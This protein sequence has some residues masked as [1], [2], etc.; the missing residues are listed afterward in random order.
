MNEDQGTPGN[1]APDMPPTNQMPGMVPE[2]PQQPAVTPQSSESPG[3]SKK[4]LIIGLVVLLLV[5]ILAGLWFFVFNKQDDKDTPAT[6]QSVSAPDADVTHFVQVGTEVKY[7]DDGELK[8]LAS[9]GDKDVVVEAV[10]TDSGTELRY[11]SYK[12]VENGARNLDAYG[13][14]TA[15]GKQESF[16]FVAGKDY[17]YSNPVVSPDGSKII[18]EESDA[19]GFM[20]ELV[21]Y[22]VSDGSTKQAYKP[23]DT[24]SGLYTMVAWKDDNTAL[25]QVQT[26]R[27]CDGPRTAELVALDINSG[28][29][30]PFY[31][32]D[33]KKVGY[34]DFLESADGNSL[35]LYG[36][37]FNRLFSGFDGAEPG[38][39]YGND[40]IFSINKS[41]GEA[42]Q[43]AEI[44]ADNNFFGRIIGIADDGIY[45]SRSTYVK[46]SDPNA[47][48]QHIELGN[49]NPV[50]TLQFLPLSTGVIRDVAM[51]SS[52]IKEKTFLH[53]VVTTTDGLLILVSNTDTTHESS[54]YDVLELPLSEET[55]TISSL[56]H[57]TIKSAE[58]AKLLVAQ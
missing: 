15:D 19:D 21:I 48:Y 2:P 18:V 42:K 34:A 20:S 30:A 4:P 33:S 22:N 12:D 5:A 13:V 41:T 31:K 45:L 37:D 56:L 27:Q 10:K 51:E 26:C 29:I 39:T 25:L 1:Q 11:V 53:Q 40:Y 32:G 50:S 23:S 38:T 9:V 55:N 54:A 14:L 49:Y 58:P 36:G 52:V 8:S 16:K 35:Y 17:Y 43:L 46:T 7:L 57:H 6:N 44:K 3:K 24:K 28:I 47:S